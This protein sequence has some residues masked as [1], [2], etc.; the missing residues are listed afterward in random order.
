[1]LTVMS[2]LFVG[3]MKKTYGKTHKKA[4][5]KAI[6]FAVF[7]MFFAMFFGCFSHQNIAYASS[8]EQ[9]QVEE[10]MS[11]AVNSLLDDID[12]SALTKLVELIN[13]NGGEVLSFEDVL[14][15][16]KSVLNGESD[17]F[18]VRIF[19]F[20][21]KSVGR[22]FLG[23]LPSMITIILLCILKNMLGSLTGD[24][25]NHSTT[26]IVH[27][28][29][30]LA[31]VIVLS[32]GVMNVAKEVSGTI[33]LLYTLLEVL[34]PIL[35]GL[36]STLGATTIVG[37]YTSLTAVLGSVIL[38]MITSVILPIF[39]ASIVFSVVGGVS[40]S[41]KLDKLIKLLRS[42][43]TWLIGIVFGLFASFLTLQ[44]VSGGVTD[45]FGFGVAKFA[46][47]SYVPILGG[48]LSD[49]LDILTASVVLVKN[50]VG[51]T[52]A[53]ILCAIVL[54]PIVKVV[55]FS[56]GLRICASIAEPVGDDRVA[57]LMTDVAKNVNLLVT[58]LA[59]VAFLFFLMIM[60]IIATCNFGV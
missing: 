10:D 8:N 55:V 28:V 21:A 31:I 32:T 49:G 26:E 41:V 46:I 2:G 17:D 24:F 6:F 23:V 48:Y 52:G 44:G 40:K 47:S 34:F 29:C 9:E 5:K 15:E 54:F 22:Y 37:G 14:S 33:N 53:I 50:A 25:L 51:Y 27:I 12:F 11:D 56:L 7:L 38:K 18:F 39:V 3:D 45:K 57:T 59:G 4:L 20:L 1:M 42:A 43:S 13:Q 58:A 16:I 60:M 35:L 36:L 19:D 30:Y